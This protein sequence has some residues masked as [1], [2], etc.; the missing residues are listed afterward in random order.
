MRVR[1]WC[2]F[3]LCEFV[4]FCVGLF[5][6]CSVFF[7][8][9]YYITHSFI[10]MFVVFDFLLP[11][12]CLFLPFFCLFF[13]II[14]F[15]TQFSV[16]PSLNPLGNSSSSSS[17]SK[18]K[19]SSTSFGTRR[20]RKKGKTSARE[21][22]KKTGG[23]GG[24]GGSGG[25]SGESGES[26]SSSPEADDEDYLWPQIDLPAEQENLPIVAIDM[27]REEMEEEAGSSSSSSSSSSRV[28]KVLKYD[29][30]AL[31]LNG[32]VARCLRNYQLEGTRW[33]CQKYVEKNGCILGDDMGMGMCHCVLLQLVFFQ[34]VF[35]FDSTFDSTLT[36]CMVFSGNFY[37]FFFYLLFNFRLLF[38][39]NSN[40]PVVIT[41]KTIQ[42]V[43]NFSRFCS[44]LILLLIDL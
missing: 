6:V 12:F 41:G 20:T 14:S 13:I 27:V 43:R 15:A 9:H 25:E 16:D 29:G 22:D 42:I 39:Q 10:A 37:F 4:T 31:Q 36:G 30:V 34:R 23:G 5:C 7:F 11:F 8:L 40:P 32:R 26:S 17:S 21:S 28:G 33:L 24:G 18:V 19:S 2:L 38:S 35:L 44:I 1:F 3:F